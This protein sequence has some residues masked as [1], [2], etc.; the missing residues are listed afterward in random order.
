LSVFG[1][2]SPPNSETRI[3]LDVGCGEQPF[4]K[5][6]GLDQYVYVGIEIPAATSSFGMSLSRTDIV[7]Y[8]G[9]RFPVHSKSVDLVLL[10]EVFEHVRERSKL[11]NEIERVLTSDGVV[12]VSVPW[13]ARIHFRPDDYF[14][15]T[16]FEIE[17]LA[18]ESGLKI[19][20]V[21]PRGPS[22]AVIAN[23]LLIGLVENLRAGRPSIVLFLLLIPLLGVLQLTGLLGIKF[24]I[25][26]P[27]DPLGFTFKL[28][29]TI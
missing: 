20:D 10:L 22:A 11:F 26:N 15:P 9:E 19:V 12:I 18:A 1:N 3:L 5:L 25:S 14:R 2:C 27:S 29:K 4:R 8:D 13:S 28:K 23:K 7:L 21:I 24:G 17:R 6:R 16:P